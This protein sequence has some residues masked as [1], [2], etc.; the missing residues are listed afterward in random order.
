MRFTA[1]IS[2][3][4]LAV[5]GAAFLAGTVAYARFIDMA[6]VDSNTFAL[7]VLNAPTSVTATGGTTITL[8]WTAT[9]DTYA[10][11][12]RIF[13]STTSG[14]PYSQV[15]Q[16]TPRTTTTFV[17]SPPVG[18]NFYVVRAYYQNW[19]SN[20]SNEVVASCC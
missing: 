14:G 3:L 6:P 18:A 7:D 16:V 1:K 9:P 19:E 17:D 5:A 12:Y 8:N 20:N 11:G 13:R 15:G 2:L 10:T 4:V